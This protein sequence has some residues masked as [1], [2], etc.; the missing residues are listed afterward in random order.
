MSSWIKWTKKQLL[1][2]TFDYLFCVVVV[3]FLVLLTYSFNVKLKWNINRRWDPYDDDLSPKSSHP[4]AIIF[5][6]IILMFFFVLHVSKHFTLK[7]DTKDLLREEKYTQMP[8]GPFND[9]HLFTVISNNKK[10]NAYDEK[11]MFCLKYNAILV[12]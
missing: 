7:R 1:L 2:I 4:T 10:M 8:E 12:N 3:S 6:R 11:Q 5:N 9:I